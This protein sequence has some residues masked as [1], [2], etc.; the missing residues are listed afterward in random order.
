M[1]RTILV[2][3]VLV[4][5]VFWLSLWMQTVLFIIGL[6]VARYYMLIIIPAILSD[7]LYAPTARL[8]VMQLKMTFL[9]GIVSTLYWLVLH[10]TRIGEQ[11]GG[12][13]R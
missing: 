5:A 2:V 11:Y 10:K 8:T 12:K 3:L 6:L 1:I 13:T 9:V 4:A 7:V